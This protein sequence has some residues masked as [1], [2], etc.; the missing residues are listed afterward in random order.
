LT[1]PDA[2][3]VLSVRNLNVSF[4]YEGKRVAVV[5]NISL[6]LVA[7]EIV[8]LVGESGCGKSMTG[9]ALMGLV[10]H[11][12]GRVTA[13]RM[14]L[15]DI[16]LA[17]LNEA[18]WR[19]VRGRLISMVFQEPLIALD[20][21]FTIGNQ[22]TE[23]IRHKGRITKAT[24]TNTAREQLEAVGLADV[25]NLLK[26]YPHQLSGGMRQRV[27][28]AMAMSSRPRLLIADEPTTALDVT[29]QAQILME[30]RKLAQEAGTAV[31]LIAHDLGV[32][33]QVCDRI[34]VMYCGQI[35]EQGRPTELFS[36]AK[37][38]YTAGLLAAMPQLSAG[39]VIPVS[40]IPG[41]VPHPSRVPSGC[42]FSNR[43]AY[44]DADCQSESPRL[45]EAIDSTALLR[46]DHDRHLY[47][48]IHPLSPEG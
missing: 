25:E 20:P 39:P 1:P 11:P 19:R 32:A 38:H 27:L 36:K 24:A 13:D 48:C 10:P 7:G 21:V 40:S 26:S 31:L 14:Q 43:C 37:H 45:T 42:R 15:Q 22:F 18:G 5:D 47:A 2:N 8:G 34:Q 6:D 30:I 23:V 35:V 33:A 29:T 16:D 46:P 28:L 41:T 44:S 4:K 3:P 9:A 17:S 12:A